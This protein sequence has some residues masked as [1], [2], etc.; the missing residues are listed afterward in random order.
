MF[1]LIS[2]VKGQK[3]EKPKGPMDHV[4]SL[5]CP[6]C[7]REV[8]GRVLGSKGGVSHNGTCMGDIGLEHRRPILFHRD[9][10]GVG[11]SWHLPKAV[12]WSPI[13]RVHGGRCQTPR[14]HGK[15][16]L[17]PEPL[18]CTGSCARCVVTQVLLPYSHPNAE[19]LASF[20]RHRSRCQGFCQVTYLKTLGKTLKQKA[21]NLDIKTKRDPGCNPVQMEGGV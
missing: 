9:D 7:T 14:L 8:A 4:S 17:C 5:S 1:N 3:L 11:V 20:L 12:K 19:H 13:L 2:E 16:S 21:T 15:E 10:L 6:V 18:L